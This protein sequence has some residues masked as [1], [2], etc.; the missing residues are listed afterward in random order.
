MGHRRI[1]TRQKKSL[2]LTPL[3]LESS[4]A[5]KD[6]TEIKSIYSQVKMDCEFIHVPNMHE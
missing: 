6:W 4:N 1:E 2:M 5:F 3:M